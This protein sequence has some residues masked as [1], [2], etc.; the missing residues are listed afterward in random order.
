MSYATNTRLA[1]SDVAPAPAPA[2]TNKALDRLAQ[3]HRDQARLS[4]PDQHN[5]GLLAILV[6]AAMLLRIGAAYAPECHITGQDAVTGKFHAIRG[7]PERMRRAADAAAAA[8]ENAN[9]G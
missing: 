4:R 6:D 2:H 7:L 8:N 5:A 9:H 3:H 1:E